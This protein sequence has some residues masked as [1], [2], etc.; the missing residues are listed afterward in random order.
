M[1][2]CNILS[3]DVD[4]LI[5]PPQPTGEKAEIQKVIEDSVKESFTLK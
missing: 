1:S 5:K 2:S 3:T 4:D